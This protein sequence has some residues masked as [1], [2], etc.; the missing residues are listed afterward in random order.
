MYQEEKKKLLY[1]W[2]TWDTYSACTY[3]YLPD[4]YGIHI[5]FKEYLKGSYLQNANIGKN[6]DGDEKIYPGLHAYDGSY[7]EMKVEWA[8]NGFKIETAGEGENLI[9]R[10]SCYKNDTRFIPAVLIESVLLWNRPGHFEKSEENIIFSCR[11]KI[12]EISIISGKRKE[13]FYHTIRTP[14]ICMSLVEEVRICIGEKMSVQEADLMLEKNRR[15]LTEYAESKYGEMS[16][17]WYGLQAGIA[18]NI[19]YDPGKNRILANVSRLWNIDRGG[20]AEFCWD[21]FFIGYMLAMDDPVRGMVNIVEILKEVEEIGFVPNGTFGNGRKSFDRSQPPVGSMCVR[22]VYRLSNQKWFLEEVYDNLVIWN[23]WWIE[24]R[25]K[26]G[27][28]AWGSDPYDNKWEMQGIHQTFGASLESGMDNS[29]MYI[30]QEVRFNKE[31][32]NLELWDVA[33]NSLYIY[34]CEALADIAEVLGKVKDREKLLA[35]AHCFKTEMQKLWNE[36]LG[37]YC[38]Y[39]TD[40]KDFSTVLTPCNFY[41]LLVSLPDHRKVKR[42]LEEHF[43]NPEEFWGKW[44]VPSVSRNHPMFG[45]NNYWRGRIWPPT[46]FLIYMGLAKYGDSEARRSLVTKSV[47]LF[48]QEWKGHGHIHENYNAENGYGDDVTNSDSNYA[49]GGLLAFIG[50]AENGFLGKFGGNLFDE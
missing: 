39:R 42:M 43:F 48:L 30:P 17:L 1:G 24:H 21:N 12:K 25:M 4:G 14:Y 47:D 41:P 27:L 10:I 7:T 3:V 20:Y 40:S 9:I 8:R 15:R 19:I 29:P 22:E 46:N 33:L 2:N 23:N 36:N 49:W 18:W 32:N 5:G 31:T 13:D 26:E 35:R 6:Q 34:D 45:E 38:N 50:F 11:D 44:I 28:L 37:I 16:E